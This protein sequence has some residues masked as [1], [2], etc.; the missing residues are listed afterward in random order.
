MARSLPYLSVD[1][2]RR[3]PSHATGVSAGCVAGL[4]RHGKARA[5]PGAASLQGAGSC[6]YTTPRRGTGHY[7]QLPPREPGQLYSNMRRFPEPL[8]SSWGW[9]IDTPKEARMK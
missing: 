7:I 9:K 4:G 6:A 1:I 2:L 3:M 5:P 8:K